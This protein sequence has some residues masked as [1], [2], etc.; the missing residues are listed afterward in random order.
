MTELQIVWFILWTLLWAVYFMLDGFDLG[1]GT[2]MPFLA[3]NEEEKR[4]MYSAAGP[5]WDGNEVWLITAGGVTFA[6]FPKAYAVLFSALYAPLLILLFALIFRAVAFEF[7]DKS[8]SPAW[9]SFWDCCK[10]LGSFLPAL[11]LGVAF[12]NLFKGIP[13]DAKGVFQGNLLTLLNPYGLL[14]GILFVLMFSYH[15]ALWL[16]FKSSG[17]LHERAVRWAKTLWIY[18]FAAVLLFLAATAYFTHLYDNTINSPALAVFPLLAAV[19]LITSRFAKIG[20]F[21]AWIAN[22]G[23]IICT[24]FFGVLGMFPAMVPSSLNPAFSITAA[25]SSNP[26]TLKIMLGVAAV[27][28]PIVIVYQTVVYVIFSKKVSKED[29]EEELEEEY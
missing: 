4:T 3:K 26:L 2:L 20:T 24:T 25:T 14:G 17:D 19:L 22:G 11:L 27:F 21:T 9:R 10:F 13:I 6:A 28:V 18:L 8:T 23:F 5:F 15:G 16:A 7:R 29:L 1:M 12:A